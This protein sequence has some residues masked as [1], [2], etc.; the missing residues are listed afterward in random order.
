LGRLPK[1]QQAQLT[2]L[3]LV[4]TAYDD[5]AQPDLKRLRPLWT[6]KTTY[7]WKQTFAAHRPVVIEHSY[8]PVVGNWVS[9]LWAG[10]LGDTYADAMAQEKAE[11]C[12][13]DPFIAAAHVAQADGKVHLTSYYL[14]YVLVT[15]AN[16]NGPIGAFR[17]TV[18]K[19]SSANLVSFCG[20]GVKKTG[21]TTFQVDYANFTPTQ[22]VDILI[23]QPVQ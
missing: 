16:W 1:A 13:E 17:M 20:E 18:D 2:K 11:Y 21:A 5:N 7:F 9:T 14:H 10:D 8:T 3:G 12:V 19:G 4:D 23:L 22:N 6:L 15:G